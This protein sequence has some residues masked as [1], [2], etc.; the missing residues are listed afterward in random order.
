MPQQ[1]FIV[2]G[3][4]TADQELTLTGE[5][6]HYLGRVLRLKVGAKLTVFADGSDDHEATVVAMQKQRVDLKLG[7]ATPNRRESPLNCR[8]LQG[9]A[10]GERMDIAVQKATELGVT[11]IQPVHSAFSVVKL[12][13]DRA[14]RRR[15]HWQKIARSACEQCGRSAVPV[16]ELPITLD[17]ALAS[18]GTATSKLLLSPT[19]TMRFSD[20]PERIYRVDLLV[21]PEGGL[22]V[23]ELA[24]CSDA[25]FMAVTLGPRILRTETAAMTAVALAQSHWGDLQ[26][27]KQ[28]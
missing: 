1:R 26:V 18:T 17:E 22:S 10:R 19:G 23:S 12:S 3:P 15:Q 5:R 28:G 27:P 25:G 24:Q 4:L 13:P 6:A 8:L 14:E 21:G 16:I 9:I 20:L 7:S 11:S 2:E